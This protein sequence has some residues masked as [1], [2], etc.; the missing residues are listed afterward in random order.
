MPSL[1]LVAIVALIVINAFFVAAEFALV[2]VRR[3]QLRGTAV[4][5]R[6]ARRQSEK[7]DEYLA[8]CQL[9]ITIASLA[10]GALGEPTIAHL[11]EPLIHSTPLAHVAGVLGSILALLIMTALHITVGEQAPK[12]FAI[13]SA[14]TAAKFCALPLEVF[15]RGLRP[16]VVLL[17]NASNA[18]VRLL[19]GKPATSHA[20]Q[21]SLEELRQLISGLSDAGQIDRSDV[22][23]LSGVFTLDERRARDVMTPRPRVVA[24]RY[25]QSVREALEATRDRG[26][27]RF[28]LIDGDGGLGGV[29]YG[30]E[31]TEALLDGQDASPVE[32]L[33]HEMLVVPHTIALDL[34]LARMRERR[35]SISAVVDEYGVLDGVVSIEDIIEEI[36]GEI[37]DEDDLASGIRVLGDGRLVCRGDTS[38]LD[39]E[40]NGIHVATGFPGAA[41]IA[42]V[43]TDALDRVARPGDSARVEGLELRV[44]SI[45]GGR[46][47]R[48]LIEGA[49]RP[50]K[51]EPIAGGQEGAGR[52]VE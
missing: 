31:L 6:M 2:S 47:K 43:I 49:R 1:A 45:D 32:A 26:H 35:V 48:V 37:W 3:G 4:S 11:V 16:L 20:Q 17:N 15:H 12:S 36:V 13:G 10:L 41:T 34:L 14:A 23:I 28:P 25:G 9:G 33:A 19:G 21:A 29:V 51:P 18:I 52:P 27:S 22:Q 7:L 8:A 44:L 30:R 38:L 42:G 5:A 46:I 24:V 50:L 40:R 39:L